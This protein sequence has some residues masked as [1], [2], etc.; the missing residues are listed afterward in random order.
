LDQILYLYENNKDNK[1]IYINLFVTTDREDIVNLSQYDQ[2]IKEFLKYLL[3][4]TN[5]GEKYY[6]WI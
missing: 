5:E 2:N 1:P 6:Y 4:I 3:D